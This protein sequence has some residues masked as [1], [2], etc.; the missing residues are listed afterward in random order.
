M[1]AESVNEILDTYDNSDDFANDNYV[2]NTVSDNIGNIQNIMSS[3]LDLESFLNTYYNTIFYVAVYAKKIAYQYNFVYAEKFRNINSDADSI[4]SML[5]KLPEQ[6]EQQLQPEQPEQLQPEPKKQRSL[7]SR[8]FGKK[9]GKSK[10]RK[11]KTKTKNRK[12]RKNARTRT[13]R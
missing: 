3:E 4:L 12:I 7:F 11:T 8:L 5:E 2:I 10:R 9:G 6:Q 1:I 13:R